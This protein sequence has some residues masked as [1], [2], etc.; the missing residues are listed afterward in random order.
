MPNHIIEVTGSKGNT[1]YVD[2]EKG[3]CTCPGSLNEE[4]ANMSKNIA[5]LLIVLLLGACAV[6]EV[7]RTCTPNRGPPV[8]HS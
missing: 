8:L 6:E 7:P 3:T 2:T 1:Y 5:S 4:I